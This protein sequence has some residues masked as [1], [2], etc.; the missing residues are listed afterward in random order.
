MKILHLAQ[1]AGYGVTV[2][3]RSVIIELAK[4]NYEQILLGSD[5][6]DNE[7]FRQIVNKLIIVPMDRNIT[8]NDIKTIAQCRNIIS[9]EKPDIVYCHSAKAGI[10]GRIACIGNNIKVVYNPHGWAFNMHCSTYKRLFYK[11]VEIVF[12]LFTDKIIAISQ[13]EKNS[14]PCLIPSKKVMNIVNGID[15]EE[16]LHIL[17]ESK[18]T[19]K[20][21]GISENKFVIGL[22]AR[23]SIQKGQ[24][25]LV[26]AALKIVQHI[27]NACFLLVGGKS[28]NID[29][30]KMIDSAGLHDYF[31]ITGEVNNAI[32][33]AKLFDIAVLTSRWEGFGL[34][35]P[36]YMLAERAIVSFDVDAV[37]E[38]IDDGINGILVKPEDTD[39][40]AEAIVY[41]YNNRDKMQTMGLSGK[42]K[43]MSNFDIKRV[44]N[45]HK[46]LFSQLTKS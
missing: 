19:R 35:L 17:T 16:D 18:L 3:I 29:I 33:Y 28:D 11:I 10:Y 20:E 22:L 23:I 9:E 46:L 42:K 7:Q 25:L 5:Y 31:I 39:A 14:T 15:I 24:D 44:C 38:I 43:A 1:S 2:Y 12:S 8:K 32:R 40:L 45:E 37:R 27:P 4:N 30:E 6:Y 41:L 21:I 34:V 13:F 36:E 26:K